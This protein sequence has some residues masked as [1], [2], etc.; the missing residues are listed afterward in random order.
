MWFFIHSDFFGMRSWKN[1]ILQ[2]SSAPS[3][4]SNQKRV[5]V[6]LGYLLV[7]TV[8][9]SKIRIKTVDNS[10]SWGMKGSKFTFWIGRCIFRLSSFI[11]YDPKLST[12]LDEQFLSYKISNLQTREKDVTVLPSGNPRTGIVPRY[13]N[14]FGCAGQKDRSSVCRE[15]FAWNFPLHQWFP[16]CRRIFSSLRAVS[17]F[18]L[19][20]S[21]LTYWFLYFGAT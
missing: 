2:F 7:C 3:N 9:L 17:P 19:L 5:D 13:Q 4:T 8:R 18:R 14:H 21:F 11:P 1:F 20:Y 16:I 6:P 12:Y 15:V 10:R